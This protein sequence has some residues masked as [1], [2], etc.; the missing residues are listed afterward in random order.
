MESSSGYASTPSCFPSRKNVFNS[1]WSEF[2]KRR[3]NDDG[4]NNHEGSN[5]RFYP[6][7]TV[8]RDFDHRNLGV[9]GVAGGP[10]G[11]RVGAGGQLPEQSSSTRAWFS[12]VFDDV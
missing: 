10:A 3:N 4:S 1:S 5:N 12:N 7:R 8:G 11:S 9:F 6:G 2:T